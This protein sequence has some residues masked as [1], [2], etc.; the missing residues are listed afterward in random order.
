MPVIR[1]IGPFV[2]A[3][4]I[5]IV[6]TV[7]SDGTTTGTA[8]DVSSWTGVFELWARLEDAAAAFSVAFSVGIGTD[9][10]LTAVIPNATTVTLL[11]R[12]YWF[13]F[14]RTDSGF[15]ATVTEGTITFLA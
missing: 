5:S 2:L 15:N 6:D 12:A 8:V 13:K 10:K 4:D 9:G 7:T 11:P 14:R 3:E 1:S